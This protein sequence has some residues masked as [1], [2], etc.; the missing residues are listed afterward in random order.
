MYR[1]LKDRDPGLCK[2]L[3]TKQRRHQDLLPVYLKTRVASLGFNSNSV[4]RPS[5]TTVLSMLTHLAEK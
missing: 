1:P 3:C 5:I 2:F 4:S